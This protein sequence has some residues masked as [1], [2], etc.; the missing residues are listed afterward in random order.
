[1]PEAN[2][3]QPAAKLMTILGIF[4]LIVV[5]ILGVAVL[6]MKSDPLE[7]QTLR[8]DLTEFKRDQATSQ[9]GAN[10]PAPPVPHDGGAKFSS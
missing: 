7:N 5:V 3:Q 10:S 6:R 1:L 2:V 8:D 9:E 4:A